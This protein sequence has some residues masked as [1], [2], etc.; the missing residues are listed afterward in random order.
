[1]NFFRSILPHT[2][3]DYL[4]GKSD[5]EIARETALQRILLTGTLLLSLALALSITGV[6]SVF[7]QGT[8]LI[9]I[10]AMS[11]VVILLTFLRKLNYKY[12]VGPV[13]TLIYIV[14]V[15]NLLTNG[16]TGASMVFFVVHSMAVSTLLGK[17]AHYASLAVVSITYAT[18]GLLMGNS[19]LP[20]KFPVQEFSSNDPKAWT[21]MAIFF[22]TALFIISGV[23][24]TLTDSLELSASKQASLTKAL[25][26]EKSNLESRIQERTER[27]NV[28]AEQLRTIA[29]I[30]RSISSVLDQE[31]LF[32]NVVNLLKD[33][34]DLYYAGIF[35]TEETGQFAH[36]ESRHRRSR[37]PD[38]CQRPP[39]ASGRHLHDRLVNHQP[40][41]QNCVGRR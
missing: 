11:V 38:A 36:L 37:P 30:S 10:T 6:I 13:V 34:L 7:G 15:S 23:V 39:V 21:Q 12:K 2:T 22:N 25:T 29:E 20:S 26:I 8:S 17:K 9:P 27:L 19:I 28:R 31:T 3:P 32:Q 4:V 14:G 1:M 33:R 16:I 24:M 5:T 41:A 40:H 18:I 35:I